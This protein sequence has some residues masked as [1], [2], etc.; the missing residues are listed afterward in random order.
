MGGG[1]RT[2]RRG[3]GY[4]LLVMGYQ[5]MRAVRLVPMCTGRRLQSPCAATRRIESQRDSV[6]Q[7]GVAAA[8]RYPGKTTSPHPPNPNGVVSHGGRIAG[9]GRRQDGAS[10]GHNPV[11]V[12]GIGGVTRPKVAPCTS[13]QPWAPGRNRVAV[14]RPVRGA[15][16]LQNT[17]GCKP[18]WTVWTPWTVWTN[19]KM[20]GARSPLLTSGFRPPT[21][22]ICR[23]PHNQQPIT[24]NPSQMAP[25]TLSLPACG[26]RG[27][28]QA[29]SPLL[30]SGL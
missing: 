8:R 18:E 7:P 13:G 6:P 1:P 30:T 28:T 12:D 4:G 23:I 27:E 17:A 25:L 22:G 16:P 29:R 15:A 11:G 10:P 19:S 14:A 2:R 26:A 20:P 21:S 3:M 24:D 9:I 5:E